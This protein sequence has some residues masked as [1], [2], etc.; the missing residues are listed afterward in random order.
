MFLSLVCELGWPWNP[1]TVRDNRGV[2]LGGIEFAI[3]VNLT[4][5]YREV[6]NKHIL[7]S[8]L[9]KGWI[10]EKKK[11]TTANIGDMLLLL[12]KVMSA[13]TTVRALFLKM[14]LSA[15]YVYCMAESLSS[16][17]SET[18]IVNSC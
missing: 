8:K 2:H 11:Y 12:N 5:D 7:C 10:W 17:V 4:D 6:T 9:Y 16:G 3:F 15:Y 13:K 1:R 18:P 14:A